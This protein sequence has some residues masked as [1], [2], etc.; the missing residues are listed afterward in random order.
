MVE[1]RQAL[2][3]RRV[4]LVGRTVAAAKILREAFAS[5]PAP[6]ARPI[7]WTWLQT[8]HDPSLRESPASFVTVA[9]EAPTASAQ[10]IDEGTL[11]FDGDR[12]CPVSV[13]L[14]GKGRWPVLSELPP[15]IRHRI[16]ALGLWNDATPDP[17]KRLGKDVWIPDPAWFGRKPKSLASDSTDPPWIVPRE[18]YLAETERLAL[19]RGVTLAKENQ[20]V[21]GLRRAQRG[22][23]PQLT[24][25]APFGFCQTDLV[26]WT[27][28]ARTPGAEEGEDGPEWAEA[29]G[30]SSHWELYA[31]EVSARS[32]AGLP[33][34][35]IW[36]LDSLA[37]DARIVRML[38]G[39]LARVS[40]RPHSTR[41]D[42]RWLQVE[43]LRLS[44]T[45]PV[46]EL[47]EDRPDRFLWKLCPALRVE[48]VELS[49]F[50]T[51]ESFFDADPSTAFRPLARG[52]A[53]CAPSAPLAVPFDSVR[54]W[55]GE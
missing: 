4:T 43:V 17:W 36:I 23:G 50:D 39:P 27:S 38:R 51:D 1:V 31:G 40:L 53:L 30:D 22:A 24:Q 9:A 41:S 49:P 16:L 54:K 5:A 55:V 15:A 11:F 10:R 33:A 8:P 6:R 25:N 29:L 52:V 48:R 21:M 18:D 20:V 32:V 35:S 37:P 44:R 12:R 2:A 42:R 45:R 7:E 19:E 47:T 13:F 26:V 46:R 28:R 34:F 14:E 3:P